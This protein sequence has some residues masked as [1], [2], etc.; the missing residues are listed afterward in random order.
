MLTLNV[1]CGNRTFKEYPK[2]HK[3]INYDIRSELPNVDVVGDVT[4]LSRYNDETFDWILASDILEHFPL[5]RTIDILIEWK[6]VL[7]IGGSIE[8]RVPNLEAIC[9]QYKQGNAKRIS[10]LLYGAQDY[11][12]NFHYVCFDRTWL[13]ELCTSVGLT[14]IQYKEEGNNFI[15]I[16]NKK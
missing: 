10:W 9:R 4:D 13:E 15:L 1:G 6:R 11:P 12:E 16:V 5:K 2:G 7:K 3:C 8:F 14:P